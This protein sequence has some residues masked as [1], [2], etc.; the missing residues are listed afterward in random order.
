[1]TGR[2]KH[3]LLR[4]KMSKIFYKIPKL[5]KYKLIRTKIKKLNLQKP[6]IK[7]TNL[8]EPKTYLSLICKY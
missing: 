1:M 3:T 5:K 7:N 2:K 6:K 4:T 8:H